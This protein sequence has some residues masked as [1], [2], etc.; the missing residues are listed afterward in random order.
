[1]FSF[2]NLVHRRFLLKDWGIYVH[3][4]FIYRLFTEK[5]GSI[6][7]RMGDVKVRTTILVTGLP[8]HL[9]RMADEA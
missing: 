8:H 4:S 6:T 1:V 9:E 3:K 2:Q 5:A 7:S